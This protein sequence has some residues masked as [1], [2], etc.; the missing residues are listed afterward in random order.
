MHRKQEEHGHKLVSI[1]H[2]LVAVEKSVSDAA[3][4]LEDYT[5]TKAKIE[6]ARAMGRILW[7]IGGVLL[8]IALWIVARWDGL[9]AWLSSR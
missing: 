7:L 5:L 8:T 4:T 9:I 3:P 1:E 6:G 2:R